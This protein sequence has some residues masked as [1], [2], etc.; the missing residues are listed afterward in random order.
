MDLKQLE[1]YGFR[2]SDTCGQYEFIERNLNGTTYIKINTWNRKV[3]YIQDVS[4]DT[5]CLE[6]L[7]DLIEAGLVIK[8]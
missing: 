5:M 1:K 4:K 6:K 2:Y 8:E 3:I 7:Y